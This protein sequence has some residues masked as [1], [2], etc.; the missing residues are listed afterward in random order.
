M[1]KLTGT[2]PHLEWERGKIVCLAEI[3]GEDKILGLY[4]EPY[5]SNKLYDL[6]I[7]NKNLELMIENK[8]DK[9]F[10]SIE[11]AREYMDSLAEKLKDKYIGI[12]KRNIEI[13]KKMPFLPANT[14]EEHEARVSIFTA[15]FLYGLPKILDVD[16]D[17][18]RLIGEELGE[19]AY[20]K[21]TC[22]Y[23]LA[24]R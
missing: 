5:I 23:M 12:A 6:K 17:L 4:G 21:V 8:I 24:E 9:T 16:L 10:S 7:K 1:I 19:S 2:I 3:D 22:A 18:S 13:I 20:G 15:V 11:E 14:G